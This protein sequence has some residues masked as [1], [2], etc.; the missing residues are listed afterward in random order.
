VVAVD[1]RLAALPPSAHRKRALFPPR[2]F[3][4]TIGY[5]SLRVSPHT[6]S[7]I[8]AFDPD[9]ATRAYIDSLGAEQLARS[10]AYTSGGQWLLLWGLLVTAVVTWLI[11]RSGVPQRLADTLRRRAAA[12][13]VF[14]VAVSFFLMSAVLSLPWTLYADWWRERQY[15]RTSQTLADALGQ[16]LLATLISALLLGALAVGVY[17]LLRRAGRQWWLWAGALMASGFVLLQALA[18]VLIMPLFNAYKP[19]PAGPVR[20]A[21]VR[22][23]AQAGV[24]PERV[25]VYDGSRQSN[26]FTANVA[27]IGPA[28]RVAISDVALKG[29]SLDEVEAVTAHEIGHYALGH[30]W[31]FTLATA[32]LSM[33]LFYAT[34]RLYPMVSR[35]FGNS[36]ALQDP[37]GLPVAL[38]IM[39]ALLQVVMPLYYLVVR[40]GEY[41]A[42]RYS[43]EHA[44][45]PDAFASALVKTAEYRYPRPTALQEILFYSHPSVERRVR[46]AMQWKANH[47]PAP[48]ALPPA[49]DAGAR[50]AGPAQ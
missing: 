22:L 48:A 1:P 12:L 9:S 44:Q 23:A 2:K 45:L 35:T 11:V 32:V 34:G 29:A 28:A 42:D 27:G 3:A 18:P 49:I 41:E 15:G 17:A 47:P 20:D 25:F 7:A 16:G 31:R 38:L 40:S 24:P 4:A 6:G 5:R 33:I 13:R 14:T 30:V 26:N 8:V 46:I 43:L 50:G 19:L 37:V 21:V 10:A 36:A 39:A